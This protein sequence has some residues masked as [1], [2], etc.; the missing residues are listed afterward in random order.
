MAMSQSGRVSMQ[1]GVTSKQDNL[2]SG[3]EKRTH[4]EIG[5]RS[6]VL[7]RGRAGE[8]PISKSERA[9][10]PQRGG[11]HSRIS[12]EELFRTWGSRGNTPFN[13]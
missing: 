1:I 11:P 12:R 7:R 10:G 9:S 6:A 4:R 5:N 2:G 13:P 3:S 8:G